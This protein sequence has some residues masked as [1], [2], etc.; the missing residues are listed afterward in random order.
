MKLR[1]LALALVATSLTFAGSSLA[2]D[3][4]PEKKLSVGGDLQF[5]L[6]VG[7]LSDATGPMIGVL[8]RVGYRVAPAAEVTGR[9]GFLYGL[10]KS[11]TIDLGGFGSASFDYG[12]NV[13]PVWVGGRY[14]FMAPDSGLYG[15]AEVGLNFLRPH[16]SGGGTADGSTRFGFDIGA[17][18]VVSPEL[19]IDFRIQLTHFNLLGTESGEK[20]ALGI[21]ISAG[22]TASF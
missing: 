1:T 7:N 22:Y 21:G 10:S 9:I 14:F 19:P 12:L 6:P 8:G 4:A 20:A 13:I 16:V 15:A 5:V 11:R 2:A 17:G 3:A 18:Y